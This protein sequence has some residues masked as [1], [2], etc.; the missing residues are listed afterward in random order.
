MRKTKQPKSKKPA[1]EPGREPALKHRNVLDFVTGGA[2]AWSDRRQTDVAPVARKGTA[3]P[4]IPAVPAPG[5]VRLTVNIHQDLHARLEKEAARQGA[6]VG[7]VLERLLEKN[8][9]G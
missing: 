5:G 6:T 1:R 7:E 8:L 9:A 4:A 2:A 3:Q